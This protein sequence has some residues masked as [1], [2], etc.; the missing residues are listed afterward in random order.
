M[1]NCK[2]N[3]TMPNAESHVS[4]EK[5][6]EQRRIYAGEEEGRDLATWLNQCQERSGKRVAMLLTL[7]RIFS[8]IEQAPK[9]TS[10]RDLKELVSSLSGVPGAETARRLFKELGP[11]KI[12]AHVEVKFQVSEAARRPYLVLAAND[13]EGTAVLH[14]LRLSANGILD[15]VRRCG[16]CRRWFFARFRHQQFCQEKC[17]QK[18]YRSSKE[19]K[20]HRRDWARKYY[21]RNYKNSK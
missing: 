5:R 1:H 11:P 16:Y 14:V 17:Q 4:E 21:M 6:V 10:P 7:N 20:A 12:R 8:K 13:V 18:F 9:K 3:Q 2:Y 15:R 19:W